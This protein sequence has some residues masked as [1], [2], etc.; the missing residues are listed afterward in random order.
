MPAQIPTLTIAPGRV[1]ERRLRGLP[2]PGFGCQE[3]ILPPARIAPRP[4][5]GPPP[6]LAIT[7][8]AIL[9]FGFSFPWSSVVSTVLRQTP[10]RQHGS[11]VGMLGAFYDL[12]VGLGSF[13]AGAISNRYGYGSAFVMAATSLGAAAIIGWFL[14]PVRQPVA[15][16]SR[17]A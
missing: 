7:A 8:A 6:V 1:P 11:A 16:I 3:L 17:S 2:T 9:G 10:D 15:A 4:A 5:S 13:G 12:F 14:F